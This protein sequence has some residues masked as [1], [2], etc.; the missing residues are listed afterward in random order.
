MTIY[1]SVVNNTQNLLS[2]SLKYTHAC[3]ID[4]S[5]E[6]NIIW[7]DF[8]ESYNKLYTQEPVRKHFSR[9][10]LYIHKHVL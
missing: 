6:G 9:V 10:D 1:L 4:F 8:R 3:L 2:L 5:P 7:K